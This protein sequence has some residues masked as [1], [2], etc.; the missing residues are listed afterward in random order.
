MDNMTVPYSAEAEASV[1]GSV[2]FNPQQ[3]TVVAEKLKSSDAFYIEANRAVYSAMLS[4]F[5]FGKPIDVVTLKQQLETDGK[6]EAIGGM[7]YIIEIA[8]AVPTTANL[9]YYIKIVQ[10]KSY[11]RKLIDACGRIIKKCVEEKKVRYIEYR[12]NLE[13][14]NF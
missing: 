14:K 1:L 12:T 4:L 5:S 3:I 9:D 10:E 13:N 6:L 2:M 11:L 7:N 8:Q